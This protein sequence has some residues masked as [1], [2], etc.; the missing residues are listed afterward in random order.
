MERCIKAAEI[1]NSIADA[2]N[3]CDHGQVKKLLN[4]FDSELKR[5]SLPLDFIYRR[6]WAEAELSARIGDY[7]KLKPLPVIWICLRKI[8]G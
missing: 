3:G 1:L 4:K 5:C 7:A 6:I 8:K 2:L